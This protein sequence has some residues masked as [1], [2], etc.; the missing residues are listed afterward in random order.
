MHVKSLPYFFVPLF[1]IVALAQ[2]QVV[3]FKDLEQLLPQVDFPNFTRGKPTGETSTMMGFST[4]WAQVTYRAATDSVDGKVSVKITDMLNIP[5]Y[6]SIASAVNTELDHETGTGYE[7]TVAY[8]DM[9][10]LETYDST[11]REAKL[12]LTLMSRFLIEISAE[13][14]DDPKTLY[15]FL[16]KTDLEGL[17]RIAQPAGSTKK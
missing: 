7:K 3:S 4:S 11:S 17:R 6:M 5:S 16:D 14:I 10:V 15:E 12:Q 13:G 9:K 8:K 1:S 2:P